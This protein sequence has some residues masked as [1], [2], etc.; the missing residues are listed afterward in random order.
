[1]IK[2]YYKS[3]TVDHENTT[4]YGK[5]LLNIAQ[6]ARGGFAISL[7][8]AGG[9]ISY[10]ELN[11]EEVKAIKDILNYSFTNPNVLT[12]AISLMQNIP[13][14]KLHEVVHAFDEMID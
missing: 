6:K 11:E 7:P 1:M 8:K 14:D 3:A 5:P 10:P 4:H 2:T 13:Q 9:G 12:I